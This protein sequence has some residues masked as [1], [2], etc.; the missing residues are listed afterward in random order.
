MKNTGKSAAVFSGRASSKA[1]SKDSPALPSP[2]ELMEQYAALVWKTAAAC[3]ENPEDIKECVND[4]FLEFYLHNGRYDPEKGS[5]AA[6]LRTIAH[7]KAVS[8]YRKNR[9]ISGQADM[10][11]PADMADPSGMEEAVTDRLDLEAALQSLKPEEFDI[12]RMKYYDGMTIKEIAD[13]LNLPYE[14]RCV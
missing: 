10:A 11:N 3:L 13:S 12:I 6:F 9:K 7:R 1:P 14:T 5:Y 8:M 2:E 4:V